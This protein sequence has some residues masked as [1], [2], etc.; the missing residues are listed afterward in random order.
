MLRQALLIAALGA[1]F[2]G[3]L[4]HLFLLRFRTG[5][6][7]RLYTGRFVQDGGQDI[8]YLTQKTNGREGPICTRE[9]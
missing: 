1:M 3:A 2:V 7:R 8:I 4:T 5:D 6:Y 9:T